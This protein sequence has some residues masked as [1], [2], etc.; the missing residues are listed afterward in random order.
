[1]S[2]SETR[3]LH[4]RPF[5][6]WW[7]NGNKVE[8]AELIRELRL[9][10]EVGIGGVEINPVKFPSRSDGDD[11]GKPSLQWLSDEWLRMLQTVF[12]EA[13]SL[14][15]TCDLIVGSGWPFG[16]EYLKE[17]ERSSIVVIAVKKLN[18]PLDYSISKD[19]I[20]I[21]ANPEVSSP[22]DGRKYDLAV[23]LAGAGSVNEH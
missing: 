11:M 19:E 6:R 10:K 13:K 18:G 9:L 5:V 23:T 8:E 20:F 17:D 2:C 15:M 14:G 16:A 22:W 12:N 3:H 1:M 4:Y 7:W 21:E